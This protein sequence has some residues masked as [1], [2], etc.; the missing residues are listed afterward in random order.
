M[1]ADG[2]RV[3]GADG[4][5]RG[6]DA[7]RSRSPSCSR[8]PTR[9]TGAGHPWVADHELRP[10]VGGARHV[11][12]GDDRSASSSA[13]TAWPAARGWCC[14]T[15]PTPTGRCG[16]PCRSQARTEEL[17]DLTEWLGELVRQVDSSLLDEWEA[18]RRPR[19]RRSTRGRVAG[20]DRAAAGDGQ[21]A[22][23]PGAG[24]QRDVP[25]R[26]AR[27]AA[28]LR[29]ARRAGR[30][31]RL[32]RRRLGA[33]RSRRTSPSTTTSGPARTPAARVLLLDEST[34]ACP[35]RSGACGRSSTT[36]PATTTG[37]S[38]PRSTS[39]RSDEAGEAVVRVTAVG[40]L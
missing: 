21:P 36:P 18:L 6:G 35:G 39:R 32:G 11:R 38:P 31:G 26:R 28:A 3:R 24:A 1:K 9:S 4:A 5:A 22:R 23:V 12:A 19:G 29:R 10:E 33:R 27:R 16:R 17:D 25:P 34:E 7:T 14:A 20:R 30:R 40:A 8:P 37:G 13:S 15:S 2:H